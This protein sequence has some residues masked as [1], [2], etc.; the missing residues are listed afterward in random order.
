MH[1]E[2][3]DYQ[4][5]KVIGPTDQLDFGN[6]IQGQHCSR[7]IVLRAVKDSE[8]NVSNMSMYLIGST[9]LW[10]GTQFGCYADASLITGIEAGSPQLSQH[11]SV[12]SDA[13]YGTPGGFPVGWDGTT[14]KYVWLDMDVPVSISGSCDLTYRFIFDHS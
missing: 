5:G 8:M 2:E 11:I 6:A 3:Y 13:S 9:T 1:V 14:S 4:T 10:A 12:L 7:P